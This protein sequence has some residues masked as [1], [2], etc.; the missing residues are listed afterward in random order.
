MWGCRGWGWQAA[1]TW[2]SVS[3][4][5]VG[6]PRPHRVTWSQPINIHTVKSPKES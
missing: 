4:E 6:F 1:W 3:H 5:M 2:V